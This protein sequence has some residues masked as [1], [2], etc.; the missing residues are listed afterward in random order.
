MAIFVVLELKTWWK[1]MQIVAFVH[2][3]THFATMSTYGL[4]FPLKLL[5]KL[6]VAKTVDSTLIGLVTNLCISSQMNKE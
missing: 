5:P 2:G 4:F 6:L 1:T 3:M